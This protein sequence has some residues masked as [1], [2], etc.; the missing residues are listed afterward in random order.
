ML[1]IALV[2]LFI[3]VRIVKT[4][5]KWVIVLAIVAAVYFYGASYKDQLLELGTTVGARVADEAKT[6]AMKAVS[7]EMKEAQYKQNAD[8]SYTVSTKSL[9]LNG[10]PGSADVQVTFMGQTFT[11][12]ADAAIQALIDQAKKNAGL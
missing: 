6:Q 4:V 8:G 3:V 12:K 1:L 10:K 9:K 7:D 2:L 11:V 5:V